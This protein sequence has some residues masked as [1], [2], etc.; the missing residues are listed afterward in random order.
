MEFFKTYSDDT[1]HDNNLLQTIRIPKNLLFL[2][3]RLPQANYE[4]S[5][6]KKDSDIIK[7][8]KVESQTK[9]SKEK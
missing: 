4:K 8:K 7:K 5:I 9:E 2:T 6:G 1:H 3:D